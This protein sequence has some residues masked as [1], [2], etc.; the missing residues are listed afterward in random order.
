MHRPAILLLALL[1]AGC[2]TDPSASI[3]PDRLLHMAGEE[4]GQIASPKDRLTRQLNIAN[5]ETDARRL[6]A[7][8]KTLRDARATLE[9][10]DRNALDEQARLAG[11]VSLSELARAADD[12]SFANAAL[13]GALAALD[14]L[15]P[16]QARC[17]YVPGVEREVRAL[18]GNAA[19]VKLL[20]DASQ[21]ALELPHPT[22]RRG[23]FALFAEELFRCDDYDAGRATLRLDPDPAWRS[24]ALVAI[25]DRA[26]YARET[27]FSFSPSGGLTYKIAPPSATAEIV[28]TPSDSSA[29]TQPVFKPLDFRSNFYRP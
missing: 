3:D 19:A 13:D 16:H 12:K 26:R 1:L 28:S 6:D 10:A 11:W 27:S 4:A 5:R 14:E 23:T 17:Q 7:A 22:L 8:R 24:D 20:I 15:N 21:W 9:H 29:T 18:R 25:A 2:T